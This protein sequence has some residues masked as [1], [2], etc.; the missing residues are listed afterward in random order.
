[1]YLVFILLVKLI[2]NPKLRYFNLFTLFTLNI[3]LNTI[4]K[5]WIN[6]YVLFMKERQP[7]MMT[8]HFAKFRCLFLQRIGYSFGFQKKKIKFFYHTTHAR[9]PTLLEVYKFGHVCKTFS[10][11]VKDPKIS[12]ITIVAILF[13]NVKNK[14]KKDRKV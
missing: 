1:M 13:A 9:I 4:I 6:R 3:S 5:I 7:I 14:M 8:G 11:D 12:F 10:K 2:K